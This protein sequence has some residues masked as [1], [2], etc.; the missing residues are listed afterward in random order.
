MEKQYQS[1][2]V[3]LFVKVSPKL[4]R[5]QKA[6]A[7]LMEDVHGARTEP[8]NLKMELYNAINDPDNYYLFERWTDQ[9]ALDQHFKLPHTHYSLT[10]ICLNT[11]YAYFSHLDLIRHHA[12]PTI[13]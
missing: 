6:Y 10:N 8:G 13:I 4:F 5:K 7:A 9:Q 12:K 1:N 3:T 2:L 11:I